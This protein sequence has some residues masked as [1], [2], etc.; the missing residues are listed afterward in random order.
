MKTKNIPIHAGLT[1]PPPPKV[2]VPPRERKAVRFLQALGKGGCETRINPKQRFSGASVYIIHIHRAR[3]ETRGGDLEDEGGGGEGADEGE[4]ARNAVGSGA[5]LGLLSL[6]LLLGLIRG[7]LDG[8]AGDGGL[9]GLARGGGVGGG[10]GLGVLGRDVGG[11][12]GG[13]LGAVGGAVL[14]A[15]AGLDHEGERVLE[16]LGVGVELDLEAVGLVVAEGG[17][18]AP[19]VLAVRV[20][21]AG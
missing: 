12:G 5:G 11:L 20:G 8:G 21:D 3:L 4:G 15:L 17:G 14:A 9:G 2:K 16:D 19:R 10:G 7:L 6:G 1:E 18:N 13:G